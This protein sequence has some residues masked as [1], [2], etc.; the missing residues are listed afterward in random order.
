MEVKHLSLVLTVSL[1]LLQLE[2]FM[3]HRLG[4]APTV[5]A[6]PYLGFSGCF[7]DCL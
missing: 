6:Y 5:R 2:A 1:L 4:L 7:A 3:Q